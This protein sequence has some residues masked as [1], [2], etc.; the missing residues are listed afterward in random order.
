[1]LEACP[2]DDGWRIDG[3]VDGDRQATFNMSYKMIHDLVEH[4]PHYTRY[5]GLEIIDLTEQMNFNRGN[6]VKYIARAGFK[7]S[8]D[9]IEDLKKAVWYI[10][11]EIQ[12]LS[13]GE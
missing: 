13:K 7:E 1:M 11:R 6:A 9:E 12:R 8:S 10:T 5:N 2:V 3:L 4:P